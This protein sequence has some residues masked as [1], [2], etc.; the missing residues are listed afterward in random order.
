M[1]AVAKGTRKYI[2]PFGE[3]EKRA[4]RVS[5]DERVPGRTVGFPERTDRDQ[6]RIHGRPRP[7]HDWQRPVVALDGAVMS[8]KRQRLHPC[9]P[10]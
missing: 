2:L 1:R 8:F 6:C 7:L 3:V 9:V 5:V 10:S 4:F